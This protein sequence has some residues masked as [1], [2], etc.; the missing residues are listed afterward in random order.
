[1]E[2][3]GMQGVLNLGK[4]QLTASLLDVFGWH[5]NEADES[6]TNFLPSWL[7][8]LLYFY[9]FWLRGIETYSM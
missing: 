9:Y 1:M 2:S 7:N 5:I 8:L 4:R 6:E 3:C